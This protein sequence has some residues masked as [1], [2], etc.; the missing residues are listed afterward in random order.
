MGALCASAL[1]TDWRYFRRAGL[2]EWETLTQEDAEEG[3]FVTLSDGARMHFVARGERNA[4]REGG[5]P[6]VLIHG[7]MGSTHEWSG[8]LG[9]LA[10]G[11]RVYAVD[12]IGF[13]FSSRVTEPRYSLR[14][15]ARS[16]CEF[17]D[18]QGLAR[19][20]LV[21]HSLGGAIALQFA[22]DYPARVNR[23]VL[24]APAAYILH[25]LRPVRYATRVPFLPRAVASALLCNPRVH[26]SAYRNALGDPARLDQEMLARRQRASRVQG[27]RDA[28][29]A[30]SASPHA[31]DVPQALREIKT[32]ALIL[33][34]EQDL[35]LALRH[36]KRLARELPNANLVIIKSAGHLPHVEFPGEVNQRVLD[37]VSEPGAR[38]EAGC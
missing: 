22:H 36:G 18:A 35:V 14:Y 29:L 1:R 24:I 20:N 26:L 33:W 34:G 28:L 2:R 19:V 10:D 5:D 15:F 23:L 17:M 38:V 32:P 12:L 25:Y 27:T 4:H 21:G 6:L 9:P 30:M 31:S 8:N 11:R 7:L 37:F 3:D 16:V 13:G